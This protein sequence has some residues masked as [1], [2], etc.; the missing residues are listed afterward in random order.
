MPPKKKRVSNPAGSDDLTQLK[1]SNEPASDLYDGR[2]LSR[3]QRKKL[4]DLL[5]IFAGIIDQEVVHMVLSE[6]GYKV[7]PS[8]ETLFKLADNPTNEKTAIKPKLTFK[9]I[10]EFADQ[11]DDQRSTEQSSDADDDD[12]DK[13]ADLTTNVTTQEQTPNV[14]DN[15]TN[16]ITGL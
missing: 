13:V 6:N 3:K 2:N 10:L 15:T 1:G 4:D 8:L 5:E 16:P 11:S 7:E 9:N 14:D 12:R